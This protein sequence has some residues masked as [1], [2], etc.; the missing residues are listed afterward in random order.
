MKKIPKSKI[1]DLNRFINEVATLKTLD[2]PNVVKLFEIYEGNTDVFLVQELCTGGELLDQILK[3]KTMSENKAAIIFKQIIQAIHYCNNNGISHRDLKP[4]NFMF[5][6]DKSG[7]LLKLIDFGFARSFYNPQ[8]EINQVQRMKTKAGT[9]FFMAP[10]VIEGNYTN[11]CDMWSAGVILYIILCGYPPF[12]GVSDE[13]ILENILKGEYDFDDE[14][15]DNISEDAKDLIEHLLID[16]EFRLTPKQALDHP[17]TKSYA[18][19]DSEI[20]LSSKHTERLRNFQK[21]K[22]LKKAALTYLASRVSDEDIINEMKIFFKLD[23]NKDG[24]ITLKE[25]KE[26]MSSTPNIEEI[27][28]ILKGV[29]TDKNGAINYTEFIAATLDQKG[30]L[31]SSSSILKDAFQLF[32]KNNDGTI[33]QSE[34]MATLA[35]AESEFMDVKIWKEVLQECDLDGDGKV[36]FDEFVYMMTN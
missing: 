27:A 25:L 6:S 21:A 31:F 12:D 8:H 24:Y 14:I 18:R 33:D 29:D 17:W 35:G 30:L 3:E 16:E 11:A 13:Q 7:A 32:D 28:D 2:H 1:K 15:W 20:I 19:L 22:K 5:S 4:E 36:S 26:G 34:L 10:E 9:A 23:K